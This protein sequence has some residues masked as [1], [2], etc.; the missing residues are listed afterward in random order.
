MDNV[1]YNGELIPAKDWDY[2]TS[3]PKEISTK[4]ETA[5]AVAPAG[6]PAKEE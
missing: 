1:Y 6:V 2:E 5:K 4:K 3:T